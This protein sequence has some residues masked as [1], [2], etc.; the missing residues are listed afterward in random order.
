MRVA[1][2]FTDGV[3][4]G[5]RDPTRNP[6]ARDSY[7]LSQFTDGTGTA[8]PSGGTLTP[9]DTC[10]G[11]KGRPQSASNQ[12]A[13]LT[14]RPAPAEIGRH[15]L[16]FPNAELR[17]LLAEHSIVKRLHAANRS[18]TFA[19]GFPLP[20]LNMLG[21][22]ADDTQGHVAPALAARWKRKL[23]PSA[24]TL[25]FA[26]GQVPFRTLQHVHQGRAL[27]PDIDG[28]KS[29]ARG[30]DTPLRSAKE[31][32]AVFW[33][34]AQ[35]FTFFEHYF[36]DEAGHAQDFEEARWALKTFDGFAR[37][38]VAQQPPDTQVLIVSDHGNVE[39]LSQRTH[40]LA[41]VALLS[42]GPKLPRGL[43]NLSDVG[44]WV[45]QLLEA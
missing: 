32:A 11:V 15:I 43:E 9:L 40:T 29:A 31:A 21:L 39:D 45:L 4:I 8:L 37:A 12:T 3:G 36:A 42:F 2:L 26:A 28:R 19:N 7:L 34:L 35:D 20:Y 10:F 16:G 17:T 22:L 44:R 18:A 38:V 13:I 23:R 27:T 6:L 24:S 14:G 1:L 41:R 30:F 5:E 25:A 33:N